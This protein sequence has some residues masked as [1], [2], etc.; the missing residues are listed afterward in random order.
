MSI[1]L[2]TDYP[3]VFVP[4][5]KILVVSDLHI[6]IEYNLAQS[7][8]I[9]HKQIEKFKNIIDK[10]I[11]TTKARTLVILG[12]VKYK[13]PGS[14]IQE[15]RDIPKFLEYI[16]TKVKV[17]IAKGN[18]DDY[19]ETLVP[20]GVKLYSSKGFKIGKYGFFH[21]HAWPGKSLMQCDYL[22]TGHIQPSIEFKDKLG[23]RSRQQ[24]WL[25]GRLDNSIVKKKYKIN[26][27]GKLNIIILPAFNTLSGSLNVASDQNFSGP[28]MTSKAMNLDNMRAYLLDGTYL[29]LLKNV[30]DKFK[31]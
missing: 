30:K 31:A 23:Y 22:F 15:L 28:L 13:V 6:G 11:D 17:L 5:K 27:A 16:S 29:G 9:I 7:G 1:K 12:D 24:V 10:A 18:H 8:I 19:L 4:D 14:S 21:G 20:S 3:M 25:R 2:L 26:S